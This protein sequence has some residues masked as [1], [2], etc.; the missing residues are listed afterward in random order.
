MKGA[1]SVLC[2]GLLLAACGRCADKRPPPKRPPAPTT[3]RAPP[4]KPTPK[5]AGAP[6]AQGA[7]TRPYSTVATPDEPTPRPALVDAAVPNK[8]QPLTPSEP[9]RRHG[10]KIDIDVHR[11]DVRQLLSQLAAAA[12][13]NIVLTD[14]V[15][16]TVTVRLRNLD[17]RTAVEVVAR[18]VGCAAERSGRMVVIRCYK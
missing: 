6:R 8:S 5:D 11:M 18:A 9:L 3:T 15:K 4:R 10:R 7:A 17:A 16:G 13:T 2:C 1:A 14:E 12:G